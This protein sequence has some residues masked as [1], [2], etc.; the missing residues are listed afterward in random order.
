MYVK[1]GLERFE[2]S[3]FRLSA[4]RSSH[5]E[6]PAHSTHRMKITTADYKHFQIN[7]GDSP[8]LELLLIVASS[9]PD[10]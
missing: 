2:L 10:Q 8:W 7:G 9:T 5:A 4:E 1:V 6:L 3:T